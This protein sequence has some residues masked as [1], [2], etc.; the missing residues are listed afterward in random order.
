MSA[1]PTYL[2]KPSIS[3]R[4][5]LNDLASIA[6]S[7][8][9]RT[10][11]N[12]KRLRLTQE[13]NERLK[14]ALASTFSNI[15]KGPYIPDSAFSTAACPPLSHDEVLS[16]FRT[17]ESHT[18][19]SWEEASASELSS[20]CARVLKETHERLKSTPITPAIKL[21]TLIPFPV[22]ASIYKGKKLVYL[23]GGDE[24]YFLSNAI[25]ATQT[26]LPLRAFRGR[27][28]FLAKKDLL[29]YE[30]KVGEQVLIKDFNDKNQS[31]FIGEIIKF[32]WETESVI[33]SF[34]NRKGERE[35]RMYPFSI[36]SGVSLIE[37]IV[38]FSPAIAKILL[39]Y[40]DEMAY[41][42]TTRLHIS[43]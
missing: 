43:F 26:K 24:N 12:A 38:P 8:N 21:K 25:S 33:T 32:S 42:F 29:L 16:D 2:L 39:P 22:L 9:N 18:R 40:K 7:T 19:S 31:Y 37:A 41:R 1:R 30:F 35:T 11:S 5:A 10:R 17:V 28:T 13:I 34:T 23:Y 36:N 4:D 3:E 15:S 27:V 20:F 6:L 14:E